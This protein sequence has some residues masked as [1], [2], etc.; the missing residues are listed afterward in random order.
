MISIFG[1]NPDRKYPRHKSKPPANA[2]RRN[3]NF[4]LNELATGAMEGDKIKNFIGHRVHSL[5][6]CSKKD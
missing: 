4:R 5:F 3:E 6:S 2:T 1:T